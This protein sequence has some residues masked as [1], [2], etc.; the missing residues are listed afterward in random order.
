V[1]GAEFGVAP[2]V[3]GVAVSQSHSHVAEAT[4]GALLNGVTVAV[5]TVGVPATTDVGEATT[6]TV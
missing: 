6:E 3:A 5:S 1:Q 2:S 4:G